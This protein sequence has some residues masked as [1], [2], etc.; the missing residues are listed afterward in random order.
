MYYKLDVCKELIILIMY[1]LTTTFTSCS[2]NINQRA[3]DLTRELY[4]SSIEIPVGLRAQ[5]EDKN[6]SNGYNFYIYVNR[7]SCTDCTLGHLMLW[8]YLFVQCNNYSDSLAVNI[9]IETD[10]LK[11]EQWEKLKGH[12]FT[13]RIFL[14][15]DKKFKEKNPLFAKYP[16]SYIALTD[17]QKHIILVGDPTKNKKIN[18]LLLERLR[19]KL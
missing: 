2:D 9:I 19:T 13:K 18:K 7:E 14:D 6:A 3:I 5:Y 10:S 1:V 12:K 4:E 16:L 11:Q 8:E 17:R 15:P